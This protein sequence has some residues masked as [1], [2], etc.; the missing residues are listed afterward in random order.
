MISR[1]HL[2]VVFGMSCLALGAAA[3]GK[4]TPPTK[5]AHSS[6]AIDIQAKSLVA[7]MSLERKVAQLVMPDISTI[8]PD[9]VR[10]Y[11]FGTILNGGNSGP[12]GN[13][14]APAKDWLALADAMWAAS[15][16]PLPNGEPVIPLL[17]G[18][19]A[20]HGHSNIVGATIFPHNIGLGA[21]RDA[22]L[23][24]RIG[25]ATAAEVAVTG[26]DWTFAPTLA[27]ATDS[28]WGRSYESFSEDSGLVARLGAANI[29]GLQGHPQTNGFLDQTRVIATAKHF[30]GDGGTD[31]KDRGDTRGDVKQIKRIHGAPYPPAIAAGVQTVMASFSSFNGVKMHG[32]TGML[33]GVLRTEM[34]FRGLVV[35]DWNGHGELA[36][37]TNTNCPQALLAGVDVYM[38]PEDWKGLYATL[39]KQVR[40]GTIPISRLDEAV[41]RVLRVKLAYRSFEKPR[42]AERLLAGK[43]DML[44][45][46]AHRTIAREAVRKSLILLKNDDVL[47]LR[48]SANVLVAGKAADSVA[49]QVGGWSLTWQGGGALTNR[50]FPGA[51]SIYSGIAAAISEGKGHTQLSA[52]GSYTKRP[53]VAVVVF[54]EEPYAEFVGDRDDFALRDEEGLNLLRKYRTE[55]IRTVAVLLSG[56]PLWMN[57]ELDV[58]DAFVAAWLPGS[59]GAGVADVLIGNAVGKPR[60]NFTGR[61]GFGW[62]AECAPH[63]KTLA[64]FG[65]GWSYTSRPPHRTL[66]TGCSLLTRDYSNGL[67]LFDRGLNPAVTASAED[68]GGTTPLANLVG[69]SAAQ[70]LRITG[71]DRAVQED[72]RRLTWTRPG[73]LKLNWNG[74]T[75]PRHAVIVLNIQAGARPASRITLAPLGVEQGTSLDVT[76]SFE[77]ASGKGWRKL[78]VP[79]VCLGTAMPNGVALNANGPFEFEL[80][81]FGVLP[82][83]ATV[84]CKGPF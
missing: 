7:R 56:R 82:G 4:P 75:L 21:T 32:N 62:P 23:V 42:P 55:G 49:R 39:V 29:I 3:I 6:N 16:A 69:N 77:L 47:P 5:A 19:D 31:G 73:K 53:D 60:Y 27:V 20:V 35:G 1:R 51:T 28:R 2:L 36:G 14:L 58:A 54:G 81:S 50:D 15:T 22:K 44:G 38:V 40:D 37:C 48:S 10:Q 84:D 18:A 41:T 26:I 43:W 63:G 30:L 80:D 71:F 24:E 78:Q 17:W 79:L 74:S 11:R 33:T 52:D 9:D 66:D 70:A 76:S 72:A 46:P 8:T 67:R 13:D 59:E 57:R 65:A 61:L 64:L 12:G 25:A 68:E 83:P 34:G 45:S